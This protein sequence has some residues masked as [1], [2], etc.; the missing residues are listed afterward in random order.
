M[1]QRIWCWEPAQLGRGPDWLFIARVAPEGAAAL[2]ALAASGAPPGFAACEGEALTYIDAGSLESRLAGRNLW[3]YNSIQVAGDSLSLE[4]GYGG[5]GE[6]LNRAETDFLLGLLAAPG[7]TLCS[8]RVLAGGDGYE[9]S[10][11]RGGD[12]LAGLLAYL[13]PA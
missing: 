6:Q 13:G 3:V 7:V 4:C 9:H 12:D 8:W 5:R 2:A 1:G 10:T 11:L